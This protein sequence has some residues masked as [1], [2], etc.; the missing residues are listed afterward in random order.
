MRRVLPKSNSIILFS[1][2]TILFFQIAIGI[3]AIYLS[4]L[5][6]NKYGPFYDSLSYFNGLADMHAR[7]QSDGQLAALTQQIYHSSVFYPWLAFAPF[8]ST[9]NLDRSIA[10][11]IQVFASVAM[12]FAVFAYFLRSRDCIVALASS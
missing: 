6:Y 11:W 4:R 2:L 8:A 5:F 1:S 9:V 7:A 10:T 12:Q 3:Y